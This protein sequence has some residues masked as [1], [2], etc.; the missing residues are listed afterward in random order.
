MASGKLQF[1]PVNS[2]VDV[3]FWF[4][5]TQ[6]KLE[7]FKL[8]TSVRPI[9]GFYSFSNDSSIPPLL[10]ITRE[11]LNP[12]MSTAPLQV[13][14]P[15]FLHVCN[16]IEEFKSAD[17]TALM[18]RAKARLST[19][20]EKNVFL[21]LTYPDLK[22][23]LFYYWFAFP[24]MTFEP[25][26]YEAVTVAE[27]LNEADLKQALS[28]AVSEGKWRDFNGFAGVHSDLSL[29]PI[30]ART[31]ATTIVVLDPVSRADLPSAVVRNY[32][33]Q[34]A[35]SFPASKLA[36]V[37]LKD[38]ITADPALIHFVASR[39]FTVTLPAPL[40]DTD[41]VGWELNA[42]GKLGPKVADL[43]PHMDPLALVNSA[44]E[45]NL[46]LMRW[47]LVPEL[48]LELIS[49]QRCLLFGAGT[50]GCNIARCLLA[51]GVR[52]ITLVDSGKV[53]YS[54][55]V[56]QSLYTFADCASQAPKAAAAAESLKR[57]L[58]SLNATGVQVQIPMPGHSIAGREDAVAGD[59]TLISELVASHDVVFLLTDSRESRWLPTVLTN[60][61]KKV[62]ITAALG[63]E[64][65]LVM[66]HGVSVLE[67]AAERLGCYFCNDVVAPRNS[68]ADRT[69]DQQCTVTR[70]GVA[71]LSSSL[72]VELMVN[73][74][75]HSDKS[76]EIEAESQ[77]PMGTVPHQ[78][79][80]LVSSFEQNLYR[81]R[82]FSKCT[83]CSEP[84]VSAF[85]NR[86]FAF[87]QE[88][89]EDPEC[90][91]RLLGLTEM[92]EDPLDSIIELD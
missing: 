71:Y 73:L 89:C 24:V 40:P 48:N 22:N 5:L 9:T 44:A 87:V 84:V 30:D 70:P 6:K 51:W 55:P 17:R 27:A 11:S 15:G 63:F 91:E 32:I 7:E 4:A 42:R 12:S 79:R 10:H 81:G 33:V 57:I 36:I 18:E 72:A 3:S 62:C 53:S 56:R 85:L 92:N 77:T 31:P 25:V 45:L 2:A 82:A 21:M 69:L 78:I 39:V 34:R 86:G 75:H 83:A 50:L 68:L 52:H 58:P 54:N 64:T 14:V 88:A 28:T 67:G 80:G 46:K 8:D 20:E 65:F 38:P 26:S 37:A 59:V 76:G 19:G 13:R 61:H 29:F 43:R 47:R 49:A 23:Y 74:L 60:V 41:Y 16:T 66:R 90:L 35:Q 1:I